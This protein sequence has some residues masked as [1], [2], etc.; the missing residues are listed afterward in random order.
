MNYLQTLEILRDKFEEKRKEILEL[1][2]FR[3]H[4]TSQ[5]DR[6]LLRSGLMHDIAEVLNAAV[7]E[8]K[9]ENK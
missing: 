9:K 1:S 4:T 8:L 2:A 5:Y 6:L 7:V 3:N